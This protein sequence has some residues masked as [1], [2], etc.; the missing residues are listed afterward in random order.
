MPDLRVNKLAK[1]MIHYSLDVKPGQKLRISASP[2]VSEMTLAA[3]EEAIKAGAHVLVEQ[4]LEEAMEIFYKFASDEQLDFVSP[5]RKLVIETFDADL[6]IDASSN[7]RMLSGVNPDRM[8]RNAKARA[9]LSKIFI[10]RSARKELS[11]GRKK[12]NARRSWWTG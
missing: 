10:S 2:L 12:A 6:R 5:V 9:E 7:R 4:P 1:I 8:A 11:F 3:Y